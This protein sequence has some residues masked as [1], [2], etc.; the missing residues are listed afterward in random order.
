MWRDVNCPIRI[1]PS[2]YFEMIWD[3]VP[4]DSIIPN[5]HVTKY[6]IKNNLNY[7]RIEIDEY[8]SKKFRC[9]MAK[10]LFNQQVQKNITI[11]LQ[12]V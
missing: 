5:V 7:K 1:Y 2:K 3:N 12:S 8:I 11:L 6:V 10:Q 4:E 9:N